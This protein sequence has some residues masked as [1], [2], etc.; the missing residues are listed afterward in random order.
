MGIIEI[1]N[2]I[3]QIIAFIAGLFAPKHGVRA[4]ALNADFDCAP[5]TWSAPPAVVN[6]EFQGTAE[7]VCRFEGNGSGSI[8]ALRTHML[9]QLPK[10]QL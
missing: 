2:I 8:A 7:V 10:D 9:E 6:G 4:V 1:I 5:V 3:M